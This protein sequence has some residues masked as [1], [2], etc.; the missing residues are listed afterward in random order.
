MLSFP[1]RLGR[2]LLLGACL[3]TL[4]AGAQMRPDTP[5]QNFRFPVFGEDGYKIWE[6]RGAEGRYLSDTVSLIL[7]LDLKTYTGGAEM[8]LEHRL[9][10]PRALINFEHTT[11]EGD[12]SLFVT[13]PGFEIQ[14][15]QWSW[16]GEAHRMVIAGGARVIFSDSVNIL[17]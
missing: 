4:D 9:R 10:S 2:W 14:G 13:G 16:D 12:S 6:L 8:V 11:A 17:R 1:H 3:W 15:S 7:G 5:I